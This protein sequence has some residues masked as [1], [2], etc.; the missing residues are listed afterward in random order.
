MRALAG[1]RIHSL[2]ADERDGLIAAFLG[3]A[4][5]RQFCGWL[6][7]ADIP[8]AADVLDGTVQWAPVVHRPDITQAVLD[9]C[10]DCVQKTP[11]QT[12]KVTRARKLWTLLAGLVDT[13]DLGLMPSFKLGADVSLVALPEAAAC[14]KAM[15]GVSYAAN[16]G[17]LRR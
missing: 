16:V 3:D 6:A 12:V 14:R 2:T 1:S 5:A 11:D 13:P 15:A 4:A 9:L 10:V 8:E 17:G 7:S